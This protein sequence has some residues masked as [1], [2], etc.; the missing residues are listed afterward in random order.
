M[1]ISIQIA[2]QAS[3]FFTCRSIPTS[4]AQITTRVVIL[5]LTNTHI[6]LTSLTIWQPAPARCLQL[7]HQVH[8]VTPHCLYPPSRQPTL[9]LFGYD[10]LSS[11]GLKK[12]FRNSWKDQQWLRNQDLVDICFSH[13]HEISYPIAKRSIKINRTIVDT[14]HI[15]LCNVWVCDSYWR[16]CWALT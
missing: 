3:S 11:S 13:F 5:C 6:P 1:C 12:I 7:Q 16:T 8:S 2:N 15:L 10:C 9:T 14:G 4:D